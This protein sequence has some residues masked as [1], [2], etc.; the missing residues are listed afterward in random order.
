MVT[1]FHPPLLIIALVQAKHADLPWDLILSS[2]LL[3]NYK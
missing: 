2:E 3:G 1:L